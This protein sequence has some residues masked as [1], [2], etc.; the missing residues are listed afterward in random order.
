MQEHLA[1]PPLWIS[2]TDKRGNR[3]LREV[4]E[5][6]HRNW[7]RV[8]QYL[9]R[10]DLDVAPA[11]EILEETCHCVSRAIRRNREANHVRDLDSYLFWS[12]ARKY[13]RR[14]ALEERIR[15]VDNVQSILDG[16]GKA[17]RSWA[18]M[19]HDKI[20]V[21]QFLSYLEPKFRVMMICRSQGESWAEIGRRFGISAHNA[22]VQ[23]GKAIK[24]ARRR[25]FGLG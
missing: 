17:D 21:K 5:A 23:F 12:F 6:A 22:E 24:K 7:N 4:I 3:V 19:L 20:L 16:S 14:L 13:S 9:R 18:A 10:E 8:L 2:E 1:N 11:A 25:F 15:Y